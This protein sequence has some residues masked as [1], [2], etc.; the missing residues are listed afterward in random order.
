MSETNTV[1]E[2][3]DTEEQYAI[4]SNPK[5]PSKFTVYKPKG[6]FHFFKVKRD[7]G[8]LPNDL[9]GHFSSLENG[10]KLVTKYLEN[11]KETFSVRSERLH[12]E[13]QERH[14]SKAN[15]GDNK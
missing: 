5:T 13:R 2:F 7:V 15:S 3:I 6:N 9:S 10:I 8:L 4:L 11:S 14:A 1:V 12:K